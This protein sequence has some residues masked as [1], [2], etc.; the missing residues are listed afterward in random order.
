MTRVDAAALRDWLVAQAITISF[1]PTALAES[2]MT[3]DWPAETALRVLLTG[4]DALRVYPPDSL[5]FRVFNNYGPTEC[6][7]VTTSV[8]VWPNA[9]PLVPPTIGRPIANSQVYILDAYRNPVPIGV[10]GEIY[11][12]GDGVARGYL[13]RPELT[14]ERFIHHSFD[15]KPEQ[16]LYKTR[17]RARYLPD[18]NIQFLGRADNQVKVRGYRIE[19]G[20]IEAVLSRHPAVL[21]VVVVRRYEVENPKSKI[22]NPKSGKRLVVYVVYRQGVDVSV[23]E[24]RSFLKQKLPVYMIPSVF[25]VLDALPLSPNGKVDRK[26]LP[27]PDQSRPE[28]EQGYQAPRTP[29]EERLAE[30]WREVLKLQRVGIRDNFFDLGGHSL[31]ATQVI[32]RVRAAF[33]T[34]V[35]LRTL[36]EKP[37]VAELANAILAQQAEALDGGIFTDILDEIKNNR[38]RKPTR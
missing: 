18:G 30:I 29:M 23:N 26:A 2:L 15:G 13:N 22:E 6:T 35:P 34:E 32:S 27:A 21:E 24:L 9:H 38:T 5:P 10:I 20:E 36:F 33:Q 19:L 4:G 3:L 28:L 31:L 16:R 17:D 37:R 14:A 1:V 7:V 11:T 25:V 8:Q 12:G